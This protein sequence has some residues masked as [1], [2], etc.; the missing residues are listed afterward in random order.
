MEKACGFTGP[1]WVSEYSH[2]YDWCVRVDKEQADA[3]T[4]MRSDD[5]QN[6]CRRIQ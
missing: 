4:K 6:K 1:A 3:G 2:H 5:L